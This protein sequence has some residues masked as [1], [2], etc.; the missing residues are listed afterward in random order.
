[1]LTNSPVSIWYN[2]LQK[3]FSK[4]AIEILE[5][6]SNNSK[7]CSNVMLKNLA[8]LNMTEIASLK[9]IH[10]KIIILKRNI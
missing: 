3:S 9:K 7:I 4:Q 8:T 2:F 10:T 6:N 5:F 1:M